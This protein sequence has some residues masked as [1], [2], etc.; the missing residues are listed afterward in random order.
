M[1]VNKR[2]CYLLLSNRAYMNQMKYVPCVFISIL[3]WSFFFFFITCI[4]TACYGIKLIQP[5]Y[6]THT[7]FSLQAVSGG[8]VST[9]NLALDHPRVGHSTM[10]NLDKLLLIT[11]KKWTCRVWELKSFPF[12]LEGRCVIQVPGIMMYINYTS[13]AAVFRETE[14]SSASYPVHSRPPTGHSLLLVVWI[15]SKNIFNEIFIEFQI[16]VP[17]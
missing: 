15:A 16:N 17:N 4:Q 12:L 3:D 7:V 2:N 6:Q 9:W 14:S 8:W 5:T 1:R 13:G 10:T 11:A